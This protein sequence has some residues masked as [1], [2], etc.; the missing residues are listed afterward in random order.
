M[1]LFRVFTQ[2]KAETILAFEGREEIIRQVFT[3]VQ[4]ERTKD[5]ILYLQKL[6]RSGMY[7][8]VIQILVTIY[9]KQY[10]DAYIMLMYQINELI[11]KK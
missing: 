10:D 5:L 9:D 3:T 11:L 7:Q 6:I 8:M 4:S 1:S 2:Q